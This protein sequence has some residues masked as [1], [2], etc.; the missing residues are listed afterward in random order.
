MRRSLVSLAVATLLI[1]SGARTPAARLPLLDHYARIALEDWLG[2]SPLLF[3]AIYVKQPGDSPAVFHSAVDGKGPTVTLLEATVGSVTHVLGG[4]N[5]VS[6]SSDAGF[7]NVPEDAKRT[8][9]IFNLT[10]G[11][12]HRQRPSYDRLDTRALGRLQSYNSMTHGPT[13]GAGP[14]VWVDANQ[15]GTLDVGGATQATFGGGQCP[16]FNTDIVGAIHAAYPACGFNRDAVDFS[17]GALEVYAVAKPGCQGPANH[18]HVPGRC[19]T[20]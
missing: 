12:I 7:N 17:V 11:V 4:Y 2:E 20:P 15:T 5:P 6:W 10:T 13:F 3:E 14:D 16:Y 8:A 19:Q 1:G 9:F 18:G